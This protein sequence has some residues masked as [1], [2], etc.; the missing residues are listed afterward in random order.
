MRGQQNF[1]VEENKASIAS[2]C[3]GFDKVIMAPWYYAW[4]KQL[5]A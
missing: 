5:N 4:P 2:V 3:T 1:S